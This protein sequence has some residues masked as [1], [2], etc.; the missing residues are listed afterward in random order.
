[1]VCQMRLQQYE[2]RT[3]KEETQAA[4]SFSKLATK[5]TETLV[6]KWPCLRSCVD[7]PIALRG[8]PS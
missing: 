3:E 6:D 5:E 7:A 8:K 2:R 4:L 1:M